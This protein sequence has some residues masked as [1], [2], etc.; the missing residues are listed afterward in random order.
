M[1]RG[2]KWE[3]LVEDKGQVMVARVCSALLAMTRTWL[4]E[5][6][7]AWFLARVA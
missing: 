5:E 3:H 2:E 7:L 6:G 1:V 4:R